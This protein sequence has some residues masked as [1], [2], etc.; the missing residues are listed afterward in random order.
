MAA[1]GAVVVVPGVRNVEAQVEAEGLLRGLG[2]E[3]VHRVVGDAVVAVPLR[4][5]G[6][7]DEMRAA[8]IEPV[9]VVEALQRR[10]LA[11]G[12]LEMELA[13]EAGAV[14]RRAQQGGEAGVDVLLHQ[15][16]GRRAAA[17]VAVAGLGHAGEDRGPAGHADRGG[18]EGVAEAD[19]L[20]GEAVDVG[21]SDVGVPGAAEGVVALVVDQDEDE[22]RPLLRGG[23]GR[24]A[25]RQ[26]SEDDR[27][28][29][30]FH[31]AWKA[32]CFGF[33]PETR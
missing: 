14:A 21:R 11:L 22:V 31:F 24:D 1:A 23:G 15:R 13:V 12:E 32:S 20:R 7:R 10:A 30:C 29:A 2:A 18:D 6:H 33:P 19:A 17:C 4:A 9:V 3:E 25:G 8:L 28:D 16:D 26:P 5:V 27:G